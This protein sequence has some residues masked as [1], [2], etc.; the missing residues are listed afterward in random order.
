MRSRLRFF[1]V[2]IQ[3][4]RGN[5]ALAVSDVDVLTALPPKKQ[6]VPFFILREAHAG[7]GISSTAEV[8]E[9]P[10]CAVGELPAKLR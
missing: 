9:Q 6:N 5:S 10:G 7:D 3:R 1:A 4:K 2:H 8:H